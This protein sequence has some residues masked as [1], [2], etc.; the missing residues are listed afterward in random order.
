M[1]VLHHTS[2]VF[3]FAGATF[4][5]AQPVQEGAGAAAPEVAEEAPAV[6]FQEAALAAQAQVQQATDELN[7]IKEQMAIEQIPLS[8]Q[9]NQLQGQLTELRADYQ[10]TV[11]L[12][13]SRNLDVGKLE[14]EIK[15]RKDEANFLVNRLADYRRNFESRV[16]ITELKRYEGEIAEAKL[17]DGNANL[18]PAELFAAQGKLVDTSLAR[19]EEAFGGTVFEGAVIATDGFQKDGR[20]ALIGPVA[21]FRSDDGQHVGMAERR[22]GGSLEPN[23]IPFGNPLDVDAAAGLVSNGGGLLPL[24][25]TLGNAFKVEGTQETFLE[26][27]KK[28]GTV[29]IPIFAMAG[30]A[31]L[32]ALFKWLSMLFIRKP[33][34]KRMVALL[35]AVEE[36]NDDGAREAVSRMGGPVGKMLKVGVDHLGEPRDLIEESMYERVLTSKLRLNS[37]LP[38]IAIC[39]ASAPLMGLL[40]TVTGIINTF[41]MITV[42]GSGDVKSL[43]GG[44][45]EALITTKFG[46]I[47]AIP[48]LLLHAF[49]SR[50]AK[51]VVDSMEKAG[52]A[53]A[54]SVERGQVRSGER[55]V[56]P[57]GGF[58]IGGDQTPGDDE[59]R[60]KVAQVLSEMLTPQT[61]QRTGGP[62]AGSPS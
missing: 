51:G 28:G 7:A 44:I 40:G 24:D 21:I 61:R 57:E 55:L 43:S 15:A 36:G 31:L 16:H 32:V 58:K 35:T 62:E 22:L 20:I 18:S 5:F 52:V 12:L 3:L 4:A 56:M 41:K 49:L 47:V 13:A 33:S 39:A 53:F 30:A 17:A 50:K 9:V 46:L 10:R 25:A 37:F 29:M 26:H 34:R 6:T 48:S 59:V 19:V 8:K 1:K 27:V 42:F 23:V 60:A 45:S 14:D 54:N 11:S 38:F 2:A